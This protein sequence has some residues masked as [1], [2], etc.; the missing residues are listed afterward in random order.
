MT[1]AWVDY[2]GTYW[3]PESDVQSSSKL[4]FKW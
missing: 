2:L 1:A 3:M 4:R